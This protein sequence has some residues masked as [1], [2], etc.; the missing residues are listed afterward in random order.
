[1][2]QTMVQRR[3]HPS[4]TLMHLGALLRDVDCYRLVAGNLHQTTTLLENLL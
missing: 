4:E 1:M 3:R 2:R